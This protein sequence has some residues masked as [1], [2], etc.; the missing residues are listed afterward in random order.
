[1]LLLVGTSM[2][3]SFVLA[4]ERIPDA[5][6]QWFIAL[7]AGR[8]VTLLAINA[9]LLVAGTVLDIT[10]AVLIFAPMLL[11]I[12]EPL[13]VDPI[14]FGIIMVLNLCIG[15]C[16]PPVGSV[17]FLGCSVSGAP[18]TAVSRALLPLYVVM[19]AALLLVTLLPEISLALPRWFRMV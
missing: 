11:P 16:T 6:Q 10:P 15:L 4:Y 7:G 14:H 13:G 1:V 19:I 17:L 2:A 12:V 5:I 9:I 8:V 3:L 18:I